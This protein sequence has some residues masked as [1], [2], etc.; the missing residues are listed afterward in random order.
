LVVGG[1][2]ALN[3]DFVGLWVGHNLFAG[4]TINLILCVTF[5]FTVATSCLGNICFALGNIKGNSLAGLA[6]SLLFI[7][8]LIIGTK[9]FGL[10]GTV[11]APLISF[12]AVS[13][14][15]YPKSLSKLLKLSSLDLENILHESFFTLV[16]TA[17]LTWCFF[18]LH[19]KT[20]LHFFSFATS[21]CFL[22]T[23]FMYMVSNKFRDEIKGIFKSLLNKI[24]GY[25]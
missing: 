6:Q 4:K 7:P 17:L 15:Y 16:V 25:E 10:I 20:W 18:Y 19:P 3:E 5:L 2:I 23:G 8:L 14:W 12:F 24:R 13:A 9:Y 22:Y 21:Y 11:I 1:L